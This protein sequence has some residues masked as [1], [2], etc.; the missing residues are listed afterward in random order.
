MEGVTF[1]VHPING[2]FEECVCG[3]VCVCVHFTQ[4]VKYISW[5]VLN[6]RSQL[7]DGMCVEK[8]SK[9]MCSAPN[10]WHV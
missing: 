7:E 3:C 5:C 6:L 9:N 8:G 2:M 1:A 4:A 10:Q